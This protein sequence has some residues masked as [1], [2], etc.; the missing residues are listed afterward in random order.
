MTTAKNRHIFG[1]WVQFLK[2]KPNNTAHKYELMEIVEMS[3]RAF[4]SFKSWFMW[5]LG[6]NIKFENDEFTY[7]PDVAE[8]QEDEN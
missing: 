8:V 2:S 3:P 5:K 6:A 4:E 1:R 7:R